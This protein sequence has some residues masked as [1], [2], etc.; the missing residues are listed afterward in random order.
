[1]K[2]LSAQQEKIIQFI[3]EFKK[4]NDCAPTVYE[5][6]EFLKIRPSTAFAHIS[7]L[8]KKNILCRSSQARSI[9][10]VNDECKNNTYFHIPLLE[11]FCDVDFNCKTSQYV[12]YNLSKKY[13]RFQDALCALKINDKI[14]DVISCGDVVILI[15]H[16]DHFVLKSGML[17]L[18]WTQDK[19]YYFT[20]YSEALESSHKIIAAAIEIQRSF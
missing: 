11:N 3:R 6:A 17:I 9:R 18:A 8:Q 12:S 5:I 4:N 14:D 19:Q 16:P 13:E 2:S 7:A 10:L 15:R 1:M 20:R